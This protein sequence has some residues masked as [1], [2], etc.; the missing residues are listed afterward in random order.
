MHMISRDRGHL[1]FLNTIVEKI[2]PEPLLFCINFM[3]KKTRLKFPKSTIQ[4]FGFKMTPPP[5][6]LWN[7]NIDRR[8]HLV[9]L[10]GLFSSLF[11]ENWWCPCSE[12]QSFSNKLS[13]VFQPSSCF[14]F[15][16]KNIWNYIH[17]ALYLWCSDWLAEIPD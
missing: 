14:A 11:A 1:I 17:G 9:I 12:W 8:R 2:Y 6:S 7:H 16:L 10:N 15:L 13:L 3:F 5:P 4:I